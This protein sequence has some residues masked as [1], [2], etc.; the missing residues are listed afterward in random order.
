MALRTLTTDTLNKRRVLEKTAV[1]RPDHMNGS[2]SPKLKRVLVELGMLD[3]TKHE[4][5]KP[6]FQKRK[7]QRTANKQCVAE[8]QVSFTNKLRLEFVKHN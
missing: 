8:G 7:W 1:R 4:T 5:L 3:H 2:P 6:Y